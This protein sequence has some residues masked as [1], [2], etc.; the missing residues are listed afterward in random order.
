MVLGICPICKIENFLTRFNVM[1]GSG[2]L[3]CDNCKFTLSKS[4]KNLQINDIL[5]QMDITLTWIKDY[6][7][8]INMVK[9]STERL[10]ELRLQV[11]KL[12]IN[13]N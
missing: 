13:P 6:S 2:I 11:Q 8:N 4:S 3:I 9:N 7:D 5:R 1:M 10:E 12:L